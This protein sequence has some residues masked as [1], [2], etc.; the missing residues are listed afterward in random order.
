MSLLC[1]FRS[2]FMN[3]M[4]TS[5]GDRIN[6]QEMEA[7]THDLIL[8]EVIKEMTKVLRRRGQQDADVIAQTIDLLSAQSD[9]IPAVVYLSDHGESLGE[10]GLY[11]HAAPYALAPEAQTHVPMVAWLSPGLQQR[12]GVGQILPGLPEIGVDRDAGG[13]RPDRR[14]GKRGAIGFDLCEVQVDGIDQPVGVRQR[15]EREFVPGCDVFLTL[16]PEHVLVF[17]KDKT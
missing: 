6:R 14:D 10:D 3:D 13:Q 11:L 17:A 1:D 15:S 7:P 12:S 8:T 2:D 4:K 16:N 5:F 9:V